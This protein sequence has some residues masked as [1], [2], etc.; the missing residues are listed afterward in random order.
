MYSANL[1]A[2]AVK[3]IFNFNYYFV[4]FYHGTMHTYYNFCSEFVSSLSRI[5]VGA[6]QRLL[7]ALPQGFKL[8]LIFFYF[9]SLE[10]PH[11][12]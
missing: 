8:L 5:W 10:S 6:A 11:V 1:Q 9:L 3:M 4:I 12:F 2:I 7:F